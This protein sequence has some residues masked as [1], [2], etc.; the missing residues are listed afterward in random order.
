MSGAAIVLSHSNCLLRE[1]W[2]YG[3]K[4]KMLPSTAGA[5]IYFSDGL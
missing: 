5:P 3:I 1:A 4:G 2:D